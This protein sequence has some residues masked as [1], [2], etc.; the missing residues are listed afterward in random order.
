M[1]FVFWLSKYSIY[2]RTDF[3]VRMLSARAFALLLVANRMSHIVLVHLANILGLTLRLFNASFIISLLKP[4]NL[5][6]LT[7][8]VSRG[9]V[10]YDTDSKTEEMASSLFTASLYTS[11]FVP[12]NIQGPS[13]VWSQPMLKQ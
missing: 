2:N 3:V 6:V 9:I 13:S 4:I 10:L 1:S 11:P 8:V 7:S 12:N 5:L